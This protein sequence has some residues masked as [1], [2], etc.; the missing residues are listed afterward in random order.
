MNSPE[1]QR[2]Y[3]AGYAAGLAAPKFVGAVVQAHGETALPSSWTE[4]EPFV[5]EV[6]GAIIGRYELVSMAVDT[7]R[8]IEGHKAVIYDHGKVA[9]YRGGKA[10]F[11]FGRTQWSRA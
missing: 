1:W 11:K 2:G 6:D 3:D 5:L 10:R 7:M 4:D 8:D 9:D